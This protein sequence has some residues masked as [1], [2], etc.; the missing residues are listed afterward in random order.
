VNYNVVMHFASTLAQGN[1]MYPI[2]YDIINFVI[3]ELF[4]ALDYLIAIMIDTLGR[5][6]ES[7]SF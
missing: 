1:I 2:I 3:D 4:L 6:S 7:Q 5:M